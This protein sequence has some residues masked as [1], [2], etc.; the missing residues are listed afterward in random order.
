MGAAT[1]AVTEFVST[2]SLDRLP[3]EVQ[4]EGKRCL[5]DGT[6]VVLAGATEESAAIVQ[7]QV[8][9]RRGEGEATVLGVGGLQAAAPEAALANGLAGHAMDYDDTQLSSAPDRVFG[10]LTHPTIPPLAAG[11]AVAEVGERSGAR[12]LEAFLIGFEVECKIA[13]AIDPAHYE[14]GFHT[15]GTVGSFGAAVC[16]AKLLDLTP[17]QVRMTIGIAA[18]MASGIRANFGTM[19]K[20]LHVGRAAQNGVQAAL[21]AKRGFEADADSLDGPWG[22]F[23]VFGGGFD[24][25]RIVGA[26]GEPYSIVE[27]GVSV[28]PYPSGS[29]S[30]PSMDAMLELVEKHDLEPGEIEKVVFRAGKNILEPLRYRRADNALEAKFCIPFLLSSIIL[31]RRAGIREFRDEFVRSEPVRRMMERVE[32]ERDPEIEAEGYDR[33]RSVM[34]VRLSDGTTLETESGAYR[35]GPERPLTRKELRD[36]F[37]ECGSLVLDDEAVETAIRAVE[38]LDSLEGVG[39]LTGMLTPEAPVEGR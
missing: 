4:H 12:L 21:L 26:L 32:L 29:L 25:G 3:D 31:R 10:L 11:L 8:R 2:A 28:K 27:P 14:D 6:G 15:S 39:Q 35:G 13:E 38:S 34:E 7:D 30:H 1:E 9:V 33:M 19:T 20:P 37:R 23:Q 36:K 18:S 22:F 16:A 17:R 24:E 5:L